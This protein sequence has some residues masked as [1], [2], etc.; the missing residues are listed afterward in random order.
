MLSERRI[1]QQITDVFAECYIDYVKSGDYNISFMQWCRNKFHY[2][3]SGQTAAE[4][5]YYSAD[6]IKDHMGLTTWKNGI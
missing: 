1:W 2:A 3:I 4:I 5:V 6:H